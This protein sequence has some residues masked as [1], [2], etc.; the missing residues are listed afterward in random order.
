MFKEKCSKKKVVKN[1]GKNIRNQDQS[2]IRR[3]TQTHTKKKSFISQ[4]QAKKIHTKGSNGRKIRKKSLQKRT[5]NFLKR[6][7]K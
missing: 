4:K 1:N 5:E 2:N 7:Q 3:R 6:E